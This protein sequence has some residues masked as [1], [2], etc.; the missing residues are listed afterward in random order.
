M[1]LKINDKTSNHNNEVVS[2]EPFYHVPFSSVAFGLLNG[3]VIVVS[4]VSRGTDVGLGRGT[5]VVLV[6]RTNGAVVVV[7]EGSQGFEASSNLN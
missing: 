7:V 5:V 6:L 4:A 3:I 1:T 2:I